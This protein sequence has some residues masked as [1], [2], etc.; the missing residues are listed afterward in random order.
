MKKKLLLSTTKGQLI[1]MEKLG[2]L[3]EKGLSLLNSIKEWD[4]K[5][6]EEKQQG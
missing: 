1:Q 4:N 2:Y 6:P 5:E 3:S